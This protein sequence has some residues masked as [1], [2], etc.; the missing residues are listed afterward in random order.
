MRHSRINGTPSSGSIHRWGG[1]RQKVGGRGTDVV[2]MHEWLGVFLS[3]MGG[4]FN[5]FSRGV[6]IEPLYRSAGCNL[7]KMEIEARIGGGG[8]EDDCIA[9]LRGGGS[10]LA[11]LQHE[12]R[13]FFL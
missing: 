10:H 7:L 6:V 11:R 2:M 13:S 12:N 9:P 1:A 8:V 4:S 3:S 5:H